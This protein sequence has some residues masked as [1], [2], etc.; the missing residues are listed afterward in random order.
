[1]TYQIDAWL[2]RT[3]P[4]L[5]VLNRKTGKPVLHWQGEQLR[6]KLDD[7]TLA[8]EDLSAPISQELVKDLFLQDCLEG[9][10]SGER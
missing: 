9:R 10:R 7:G 5:K 4:Y 2:E 1:M 3:N 6:Q 8:V